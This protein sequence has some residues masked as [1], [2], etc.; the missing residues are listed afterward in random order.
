MIN[1]LRITDKRGDWV[2]FDILD[3]GQLTVTT[4]GQIEYAQG[5]SVELEPNDI[6]K[7]IEFLTALVGKP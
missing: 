6:L 2:D 4:T 5:Y 3:N 7:V 1:D